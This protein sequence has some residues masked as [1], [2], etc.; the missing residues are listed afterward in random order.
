MRYQVLAL[1]LGLAFSATG[2]DELAKMLEG[3]DRNLEVLPDTGRKVNDGMRQMSKALNLKCGR[4]HVKGDYAS[5]D[6]PGKQAFRTFLE[7]TWSNEE[8]DTSVA[9][10]PHT[11]HG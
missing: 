6:K 3:S 10:S 8:P 4:C 11:T 2:C 7:E 9:P 5:D 1:A